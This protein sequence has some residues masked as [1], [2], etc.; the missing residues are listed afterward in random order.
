QRSESLCEY[1][2]SPLRRRTKEN[3]IQSPGKTTTITGQ[4]Y[5]SNDNTIYN[6]SYLAYSPDMV[7]SQATG[8]PEYTFPTP[9]SEGYLPQLAVDTWYS[10]PDL[11]LLDETTPEIVESRPTEPDKQIQGFQD[12][13]PSYILTNDT[14]TLEW[15]GSGSDQNL[16]YTVTQRRNF[17]QTRLGSTIAGCNVALLSEKTSPD[18][19][20]A[21]LFLNHRM[22]GIT[23]LFRY[24]DQGSRKKQ[25][26]LAKIK[27]LLSLEN[28]ISISNLLR[29]T[30]YGEEHRDLVLN[31]LPMKNLIQR[32]FNDT[33]SLSLFIK[34]QDIIHIQERL[35]NAERPFINISDMSLLL[36][37]LAWG[38]LSDPEVTPGTKL[39]LLDT[40]LELCLAEKVGSDNL[41]AL[42][43]ASIS[44]IASLSLHLESALHSYCISD[45]Q[46]IQTKQAMWIVYCIDKS[47]A[48]RWHTF[49]L[50]NDASLPALEMSN[51]A[52]PSDD[53]T[54]AS[55]QWLL[56]RLQYSRIAL[57]II[58]LRIGTNGELS[59]NRLNKTVALSA[60]LEK[61]YK[62]VQTN[63]MMLLLDHS[64]ASRFKLQMASY[65]YEAQF[66]LAA[67]NPRDPKM[68]LPL[69][70]GQYIRS[71]RSFIKE[72]IK[73]S[74]TVSLED[75]FW[76]N[77]QLFTHTFA[78]CLLGLEVVM[79][80]DQESQRENRTLLTISAGFFARASIELP[81]SCFFGEISSLIDILTDNQIVTSNK[82][83]SLLDAG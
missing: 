4:L 60:E 31:S 54:V 23:A 65:Y 47:Y 57:N 55:L 13:I 38:A 29:N 15:L 52:L 22:H 76:D 3:N 72:I 41:P 74:S 35:S 59:E 44:T 2:L 7:I 14:P 70:S 8:V 33:G 71:V 20:G 68:S 10:Y 26:V 53:S 75:I 17:L 37:S 69:G 61:W 81:H 46:I 51:K 83:D 82:K 18:T 43:L 45:E 80:S 34:K 11:G 27:A 42:I 19:E 50:V 78:L 16:D 24:T 12:Q 40:M 21:K 62:S 79:E 28:Q 73:S 32:A 77:N 36:T 56:V 6:P 66:Q 67:T 25:A 30:N 1:K 58:Q 9:A 63:R 5:V 48:L 49:S 64:D 39:A